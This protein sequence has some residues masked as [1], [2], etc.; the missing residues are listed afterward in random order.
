MPEDSDASSSSQTTSTVDAEDV[1][2]DV[3]E[4]E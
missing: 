4:L 2:S 3:E 1:E